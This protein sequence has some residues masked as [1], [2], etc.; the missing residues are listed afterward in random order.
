MISP[1]K[2]SPDCRDMSSSACCAGG[3][4]TSCS[5]VSVASNAFSG[6][7]IS[8]LTMAT[9]RDFASVA[10][11]AMARASRNAFSDCLRAVTSA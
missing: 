8:W 7:R 6:V 1:S 11:S 2:A 9:K 10:A 3:S 5:S 4:P